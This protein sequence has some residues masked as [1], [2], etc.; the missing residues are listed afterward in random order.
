MSLNRLWWAC[1]FRHSRYAAGWVS[2]KRDLMWADRDVPVISHNSSSVH[3]LLCICRKPATICN[4]PPNVKNNNNFIIYVQYGW[5]EQ[6]VCE[7]WSGMRHA[8]GRWMQSRLWRRR[9]ISAWLYQGGENVQHFCS[10]TSQSHT[11]FQA[12][13]ITCSVTQ[14]TGNSFCV[15]E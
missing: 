4:S 8:L 6:G 2:S 3:K 11:L 13:N 5:Y 10:I 9:L 14:N 12:I 1:T 15:P 7:K